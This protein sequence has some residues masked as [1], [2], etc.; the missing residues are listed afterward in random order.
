MAWLTA[1][2]IATTV[3]SAGSQVAQGIAQRKAAN[4]SE[5]DAARMAAD[6]KARGEE[7]VARYRRELAQVVGRQRAATAANGV[8]LGRDSAGQVVADAQR[9]GEIDVET[10][11]ANAY[12]EALGITSQSAQQARALRTASAASFTGAAG[13][14]L[15]GGLDA[16]QVYRSGRGVSVPSMAALPAPGA[17]VAD[18]L[19]GRPSTSIGLGGR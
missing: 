17:R 9:L 7:E 4:A 13:T 14:A 18:T 16:W 8:V 11:R 6:A 12:R 15:T 19:G 2:M 3:L 10:I 5:N 1:A